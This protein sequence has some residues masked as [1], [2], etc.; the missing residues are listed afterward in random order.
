MWIHSQKIRQHVTTLI[1]SRSL[2][3]LLIFLNS[4]FLHFFRFFHDTKYLLN[5]IKKYFTC[6]T[7]AAFLG[8]PGLGGDNRGFSPPLD[9]QSF[10]TGGGTG[11]VTVAIETSPLKE[12]YFKI[13]INK[14]DGS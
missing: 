1:I 9:N 14:M 4:F 11:V 10:L 6:C 5:K 7:G 2:V 8:P 13:K 3:R 12:N